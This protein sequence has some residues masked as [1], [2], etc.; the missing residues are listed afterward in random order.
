MLNT[1]HFSSMLTEL[2]IWSTARDW[3]AYKVHKMICHVYLQI[4]FVGLLESYIRVIYTSVRKE[5]NMYLAYNC[6][7]VEFMA[8]QK[9]Q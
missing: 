9:L 8:L 2:F 1:Q 7:Q 5:K 4:I 6:N 3:A